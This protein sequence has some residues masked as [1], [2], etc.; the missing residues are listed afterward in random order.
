[1]ATSDPIELAADILSAFVANN[2]VPRADLPALF[3]GLHAALKRLDG[4]GRGCSG[5]HR[6]ADARGVDPQVRHAGLSDLSGRRPQIQIAAAAPDDAR[7][8]AGAVPPEVEFAQRLSHGR[9]ELRGATIGIGE[10]HRARAMAQ[11]ALAASGARSEVV[12]AVPASANTIEVVHPSPLALQRAR[13]REK[14]AA[15]PP[16]RPQ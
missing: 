14:A 7:H 10:E 15:T 6:A 8:D 13:P 16:P 3:E 4:R 11:E 12:A 5:R 2:S 9:V 1:M